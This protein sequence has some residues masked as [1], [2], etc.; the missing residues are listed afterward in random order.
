M[1]IANL[2]DVD[3]Y[4]ETMGDPSNEPLV[5]VMGFTAQLTTWPMGF[6]EQ[7][8]NDGFFV[9]RHDNRDSGL[10][11]KT[12]GE[13]PDALNILLQAQ[14]GQP[15]TTPVPYTLSHMAADV[16]GLLDHLQIGTAHVVGA[17]MGGM[18]VQTLAI[19]FADRLRS[20]TSIMS[21]TGD[22]KVGQATPEALGALL[23]PAPEVREAALAHGVAMSQII[24]GPLWDEA[25]AKIRVEESY[26]RSLYPEGALFQMAAIA[27][28]GDRTEGL[29]G[30]DLPFLVIHGLADQLISVSGG[31]ATA[32]AVPGADLLVLSKMGHDLPRAYWAQLTSAIHGIST[33]QF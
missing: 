33:R 1:P 21:T 31:Q 29:H 4:Y 24:A 9:I 28:S 8:V 2:P 26:D 20:V 27:A 14:A 32:N 18:I 11:S 7:L 12:A 15:I 30:V 22:V 10:S 5:L 6:C 25:E 17:S 13:P 16:I 3:I 19:E 23:A